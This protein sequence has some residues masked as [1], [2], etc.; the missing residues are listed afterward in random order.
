[1]L[2]STLVAHL[3]PNMLVR[4]PTL[5]VVLLCTRV[6]QI[7]YLCFL[8]DSLSVSLHCSWGTVVVV[9]LL[10]LTESE[11][12]WLRT[13]GRSK[14]SSPTLVGSLEEACASTLAQAP[15]AL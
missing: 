13:C 12:V 14:L 5:T 2:C 8:L 1:M 3:A 10:N 15:M 4:R 6:S 11:I 7:P 9:V